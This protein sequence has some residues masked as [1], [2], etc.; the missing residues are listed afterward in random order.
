VLASSGLLGG[1]LIRLEMGKGLAIAD[2]GKLKGILETG[3][4]DVLKEK[5]LPAL[6]HVDSLLITLKTVVAGFQSTSADVEY[7]AQKLQFYHYDAWY[8]DEQYDC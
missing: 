2:G 1:K 4:T 8:F 5:A 7:I 3:L 6:S